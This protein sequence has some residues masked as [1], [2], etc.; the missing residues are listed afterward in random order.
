MKRISPRKR[1]LAKYLNDKGWVCEYC[2]EPLDIESATRDHKDPKYK[3][4]SLQNNMAVCC[5]SCNSLKDDM[6]LLQFRNFAKSKVSVLYKKGQN[7][8]LSE[9]E[10]QDLTKF[11]SI[12]NK[13]SKILA[14][15]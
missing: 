5:K 2:P 14:N 8:R 1:R 4:S 6:S 10:L 11:R 12:Y 3:G 7:N 15:A 13:V 9:Q